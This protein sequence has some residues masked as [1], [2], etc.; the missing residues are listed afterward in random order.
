MGWY[1]SNQSRSELIAEL[2]ATQE[3]ERASVKVIAHT[4]RG[5]VL[6]SVAEMTAKVEGV[7]RDLAP[8]QS[9]RYIRC[10]LLERSGGQW[11]RVHAPVL[12]HVPAVLSGPR[13]GAVRRLACR[14]SRLPRPATRTHKSGGISCSTDGLSRRRT[15]HPSPGAALAPTG[16]AVPV[17][18][19]TPPCPQTLLHPLC[20][21]LTNVPT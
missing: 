13:T 10:D 16:G 7:H 5:N 4:L 11:G 14:R 19:R 9:L 12:L 18:P 20:I 3:T 2:I 15:F 6:W 17:H 1:F 8:D 21:A